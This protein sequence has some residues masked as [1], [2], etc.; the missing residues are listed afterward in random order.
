M[1]GTTD[2]SQPDCPAQ[3]IALSAAAA[4]PAIETEAAAEEVWQVP[5]AQ[6]LRL[7]AAV[8]LLASGAALYAYTL[9]NFWSSPW[10]GIHMATPYPAY[11]LIGG[12]LVLALAALRVALGLW[13]PHAKLAIGGIAFLACLTFGIG[14][15]RFVSYTIR[16]TRNPPYQLQLKVGDRFPDFRLTDQNEVTRD[17]QLFSA[18]PLTLVVI[19]RGDFCPFARFELGELSHHED[20]FHKAGIRIV[21]I[22]ADPPQRSTMLARFLRT[23]LPLLSDP[24]ESLLGRLG[25]VQRYSD[26]QPDSAI[27]AFILVD[28]DG[29][30]RWT[31]SSAYYREQPSPQAILDAARASRS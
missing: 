6:P 19:Y 18:S 30:V 5:P 27:P 9:I 11:L 16:G 20:E 26:H 31:F 21:A 29:R 10:L 7:I 28:R 15:G 24:A 22:S 2:D 12:G 25:L 4:P 8:L 1:S 23:D 3:D 17:G 13:S 14:G